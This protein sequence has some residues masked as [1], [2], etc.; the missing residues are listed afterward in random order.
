VL[1]GRIT[2]LEAA[3][4]AR[5]ASPED[6]ADLAWVA[7]RVVL[8]VPFET[9]DLTTDPKEAA[10]LGQALRRLSRL[11]SAMGLRAERLGRA[12]GRRRWVLRAV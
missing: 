10:R 5:E 9:G 8:D 3:R 7:A 6:L 11:S 4:P 1:E 12:H 2:A